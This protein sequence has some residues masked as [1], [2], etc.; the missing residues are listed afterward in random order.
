MSKPRIYKYGIS[1][2][3]M[4]LTLPAIALGVEL[5]RRDVNLASVELQTDARGILVECE[6]AFLRK[7]EERRV[8]GAVRDHD[9]P[10]SVLP[11]PRGDVEDAVV[12]GSE[13]ARSK[14]RS[15]RRDLVEEHDQIASRLVLDDEQQIG[16]AR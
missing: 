11:V 3:I 12:D 4:A 1:A 13:D 9:S 5:V 2:A 7:D 16:R 14:D 10:K 15:A 6:V 8:L